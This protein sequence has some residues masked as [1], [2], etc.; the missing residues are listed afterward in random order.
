M[1]RFKFACSCG[2]R[3]AAYDWMVGRL[4]SCPKCGRTLTVPTPF[5]AEDHFKRMIE[6]G[7]TPERR[8]IGKPVERAS[9][10][11]RI[12]IVASILLLVLAATAVVLWTWVLH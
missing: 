2:K 12:V 9:R 11:K 7:Y 1:S 6:E 5:Q 4:V 3:L 10:T 8:Q